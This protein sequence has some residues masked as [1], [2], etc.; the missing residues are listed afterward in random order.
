MSWQRK[1]HREN[2]KS[3]VLPTKKLCKI[4]AMEYFSAYFLFAASALYIIVGKSITLLAL[5]II[6]GAWRVM[7]V[8][9]H[10]QFEF[11]H[12]RMRRWTNKEAVQRVISFRRFKMR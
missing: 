9:L 5:M 10:L 2:A 7:F 11:A 12:F 3:S 1:A 4:Q 8:D 6:V